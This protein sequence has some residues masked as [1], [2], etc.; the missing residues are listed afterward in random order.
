MVHFLH[1]VDILWDIDLLWIVRHPLDILR[2]IAATWV[3]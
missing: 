3:G 1:P 2:M